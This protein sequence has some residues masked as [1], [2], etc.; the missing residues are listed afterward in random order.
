MAEEFNAA[1]KGDVPVDRALADLQTGLQ[2]I[3]DQAS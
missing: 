2:D 3:A 1:L